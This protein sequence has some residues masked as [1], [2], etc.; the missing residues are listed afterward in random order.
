M[1][2]KSNVWLFV[3]LAYGFAWLFWIPDALIAQNVWQAPD[4]IR[5]FLVSPLNP[6]PWGPLVAA[7]V[8][9]LRYQ[10]RNGVRNL[11]KRGLMVRMGRWWLAILLL[12]P[13]LIGGALLLGIALGDPVPKFA[14]L[15]EPVTLPIAFLF[16]FF[17]GGPLQEEFGWRGYAFEHL[18][19]RFS[20]L[21][22]AIL[23]GLM[24]GLWHLPLFF[25]PR[26]EFYYNRPL[27][28]LL[29]TTI[30]VGVILAWFYANTGG[31]VF[32]AI[33]GHT[34]FN[35]SNYV[36][37]AL[38]MDRAAGLLFVLYFIVVGY[39]LWRYSARTLTGNTAPGRLH[40]NTA[41]TP[42][43]PIRSAYRSSSVALEVQQL[44]GDTTARGASQE[45]E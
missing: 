23:A 9:T 36:F 44:E 3:L 8:V 43:Y 21:T 19:N 29:L 30:L 33:L 31:S 27:W 38:G 12:F 14:A 5:E 35:W 40:K 26:Q 20:A 24:W 4:G 11:L 13:L 22:A 1:D 18:R 10:G 39:I 41:R 7:L 45:R 32:A 2:K 34:M 37:P 28:G 17:L 6:A 25:V 16:I 42:G 15:A